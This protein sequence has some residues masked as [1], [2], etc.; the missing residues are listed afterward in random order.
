ML[1]R[2]LEDTYLHQGMRKKLVDVM[3]EKRISDPSVLSAIGKIPRHLFITDNAFLKQAYDDV[4]FPIGSGQTISQPYT[5]AFQTQLLQLKKGEKVLEVGTG[6]GYQACVLAECGVKV[7]SIERQKSLYDKTKPFL[8][9]LGY[10]IN[11]TY[12]DG[13]NGWPVYAPFDKI[14]VTCGAPFI[15]QALID[16]LKPGGRMVIPVGEGNVQMMTLIEK[17]TDSQVLE[18]QHGIFRFV[19]MLGDREWKR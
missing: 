9:Q 13:Y 19:P 6:S 12:G 10:N 11:C 7:F 4:A 14:I 16:Q 15:P 17:T 8:Q 1:T 5:V 2:K 18:S 3:K